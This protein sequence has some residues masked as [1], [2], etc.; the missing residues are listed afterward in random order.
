M[1]E[2][3]YGYGL[4]FENPYGRNTTG[5]HWGLTSA[6][7]VLDIGLHLSGL[8][9]IVRHDLCQKGLITVSHIYNPANNEQPT[10]YEGARVHQADSV[11]GSSLIKL[12][13]RRYSVLSRLATPTELRGNDIDQ[14]D[15]IT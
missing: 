5:P 10:S 1:A 12:A 13:Q 15:V 6:L 3:L 8:A 2:N 4:D 9:L 7:D 14:C 11:L